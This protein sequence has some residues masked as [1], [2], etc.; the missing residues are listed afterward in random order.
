MGLDKLNIELLK[1]FYYGKHLIYNFINIIDIDNFKKSNEAQNIIYFEK[2]EFIHY[3]LKELSFTN[4]F[5]SKNLIQ[6][7]KLIDKFKNIYNKHKIYKN[8]KEFKINFNIPLIKLDKSTTTKQILGHLNTILSN[9][10]I[11]IKCMQK[12]E[13]NAPKYY[14]SIEILNNIDELLHYK[15]LKNYKLIDKDKIF[16]CNKTNLNHLFIPDDNTDDENE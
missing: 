14:Y 6:G 2:L 12:K 1:T 15:I 11:K 5:D 9:Y 3:L 7:D 10:S 8:K 13:N 16:T 4:I